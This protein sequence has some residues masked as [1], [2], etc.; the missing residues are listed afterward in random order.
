MAHLCRVVFMYRKMSY[1]F[2]LQNECIELVQNPHLI[3]EQ[4]IMN[5]QLEAAEEMLSAVHHQLVKLGPKSLLSIPALDLMLRQYAEKALEFRISQCSMSSQMSQTSVLLASSSSHS[6]SKDFL[7]PLVVPAKSGWVPN[8]QA[9]VCMNCQLSTFTMF[10][11][12]HHCRRCGRVVC[13]QCSPHTMLIEGY[14]DLKVRVCRSCESKINVAAETEEVSTSEQLR[15]SS[16]S[17]ISVSPENVWHLSNSPTYNETI[18]EEFAYAHAPSVSLCLSILKLHSENAACPNFLVDSCE[19][20]LSY[21]QP[22]GVGP[23][24]EVDYGFVIEMCRY[25]LCVSL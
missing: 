14:G 3:I 21:L 1:F 5:I 12:R 2:L 18:R 16:N 9:S 15:P 6:G 13:A 4:L 17:D 11:R 19:T 23:N 8:E 20:I 7:M 24:P 22:Q 25:V 10:N